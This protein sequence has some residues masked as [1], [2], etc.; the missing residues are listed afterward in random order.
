MNTVISE[1]TKLRSVRSTWIGA[2]S[3]VAAGLALSVLGA[4]DSLGKSVAEL[5]GDW[6][7]TATALKGFLFA[8]L[9]IG[10]LGAFSITPEYS[11]G[12]IDTSLSVVPSRSRLLG[13]KT[14]V[15]T[16]FALV[17]A[18]ATTGLSFT[19][20]QVMFAGADLPS[21]RVQ[22]PAVI[23]ALVGAVLYLTLAALLGLA[24]GTVVRSTAGTLAVLVAVL[25]LV[26]AVAPGLGDRVARYW[27]V[28]AGQSVYAVVRTDDHVAPWFG[29]G[30]L[31]AAVLG[32]GI[33]ARAVLQRRDQ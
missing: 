22:D 25:L 1:W 14:V 8:Q 26:P 7:P 19:V 29:F 6:D 24:A 27:P 32:A 9:L 30:I 16:A 2:A 31:A 15:V 3:T 5:P 20:V 23:S 11:T 28:T 4:S 33:V 17:T 13:A 10:M 21:A 18:L 12:T